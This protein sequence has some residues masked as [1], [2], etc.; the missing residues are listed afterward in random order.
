MS[1]RRRRLF[2]A[3]AIVAGALGYLAYTGMQEGLVYFVTP[4]ELKARGPKAYG[5]YVRVGGLVVEDSIERKPE[6]LKTIFRLT[7]GVETIT[8][9]HVGVVPDLFGEGRGAVVKGSL[10]P[11]GLFKAETILAKHAEEYKPPTG[12]SR[13]TSEELYRSILGKEPPSDARDR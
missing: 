4:S 7:D 5:R 9:S 2:I 13:L 6:E 3:L 11:S 12:Q 1:P 10:T 8:V